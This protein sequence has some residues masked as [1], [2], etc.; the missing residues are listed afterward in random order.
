LGQYSDRFFADPGTLFSKRAGTVLIAFPQSHLRE[1][2]HATGYTG[3][4]G[5]RRMRVTDRLGLPTEIRRKTGFGQEESFLA[6]QICAIER[7]ED[8]PA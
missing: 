2:S 4:A 6:W 5:L 8:V 1:A 7:P 3:K